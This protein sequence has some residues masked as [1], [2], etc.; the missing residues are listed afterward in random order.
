MV[1]FM[2]F[3]VVG[4]ITNIATIA[5]GQSIRNLVRLQKTY[6]AGRWR[7]LKGITKVRLSDGEIC[8]AEVH[9]AGHN[10][11]LGS[12]RVLERFGSIIGLIIGAVMIDSYGYQNATGSAGIGVCAASLIFL[13]F[14]FINRHN[15]PDESSTLP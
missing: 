11:V 4:E 9:N 6:G 12:L 1:Q 7:K 8:S 13:L 2:S 5:I 10:V 14:F 15:N 3:K